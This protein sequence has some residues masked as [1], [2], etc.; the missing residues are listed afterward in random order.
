MKILK[1]SVSKMASLAS[2]IVTETSFYLTLEDEPTQSSCG[3]WI[4]KIL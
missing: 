2:R 1:S 4:E 3:Y